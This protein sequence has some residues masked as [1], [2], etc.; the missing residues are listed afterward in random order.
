MS[1]ELDPEMDSRMR[2]EVLLKPITAK[3]LRLALKADT[4][5]TRL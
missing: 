4:A 5:V 1:N 2:K 3:G